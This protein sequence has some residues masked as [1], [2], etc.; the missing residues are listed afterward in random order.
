MSGIY[1]HIPFCK[2]A[3]H[4]CNFHFSTSRKY[5]DEMIAAIASELRYRS[6][7]LN[8][9]Q[10]ESI[11]F[12]GGTPSVLTQAQLDKLLN[13]IAVEFSVNP[14]SEVTLEANPDDLSLDYLKMLSKLGVNRLSIGIQSFFEEDLK[15]MNRSHNALQAEA[16]LVEARE[17]GFDNI[18]M[19]LIFGCPTSSDRRWQHNLEKALFYDI[20][21]LSCY[22]LTVEPQT[23]L[24][25]MIAKEKTAPPRDED[26]AHQFEMTMNYLSSEGYH[27][28][29]ISN[30]AREGFISRHNSSYWK[31]QSYLGVGPSAHSFDSDRRRWNI[32]HNIHYMKAIREGKPAFEEEV[33]TDKDRFNEYLLT[34]LRTSWGCEEAKLRQLNHS[35]FKE[36]EKEVDHIIEAQLLSNDGGV[37]RLTNQGKLLANDVI[38]RLFV[39]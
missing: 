25:K 35:Y 16:C 19:D 36:F 2:K 7:Y 8:G 18:N 12:G 21:H 34:G 1:I 14:D 37:F 24:E 17:A 28:Y 20:P 6:A 23:A 15:W 38:S 10:V 26:Y 11:Y 30:Y 13:I 9:Q 29:E 33:L 3:C 5:Q 32:S 39:V 27:H 22:G 31:A 4:Y